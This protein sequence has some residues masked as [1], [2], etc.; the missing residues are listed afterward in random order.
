[1]K[2]RLSIGRRTTLDWKR[3]SLQ[4]AQLMAAA[5]FKGLKKSFQV[6]EICRT[7]GL[8]SEMMHL[9]I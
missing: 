2:V 3:Q 7:D 4:G 5:N 9:K 6:E 1:M 8:S